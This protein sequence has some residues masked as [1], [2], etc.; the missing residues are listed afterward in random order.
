MK[1]ILVP[2]DFSDCARRATNVA[3]DIA[4]KAKAEVM[5]LH[6]LV[7]PL[8]WV[9]LDIRKEALYPEVTKKINHAKVSLRKLVK[10]GEL[11]GLNCTLSLSFNQGSELIL[12]EAKD[13]D[14]DLIVM[15]SHG[16]SSI[17]ST[18]LGSNA[19][20]IVKKAQTPVLVI[21]NQFNVS[22]V[23][24]F[25]FA[26]AFRDDVINPFLHVIKLADI[27]EAHIHLLYINDRKHFE[28]SDKSEQRMKEFHSK[29]PRGT[30]SMNIYNDNTAEDGIL[31]F[32]REKK[33][34]LMAVATHGKS[35]LFSTSLTERLVN[36]ATL[37]VLSVNIN[38]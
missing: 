23:N 1:K 6:T 5:F 15:G 20:R 32:A 16:A 21:K 2:T 9:K 26:S 22:A 25:L 14:F 17:K 36:H 37:P 4:Q 8:D 34:D 28:S 18:I 30:C 3:L 11:L 19:Q 33:M 10:K 7:T 35:G 27:L 38:I 24:N 31:N 13:Y 29:C 12:E